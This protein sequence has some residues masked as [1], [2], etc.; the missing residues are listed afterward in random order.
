MCGVVV[1]V[2]LRWARAASGSEEPG[3]YKFESGRGVGGLWQGLLRLMTY[4]A[5]D[6]CRPLLS[7][8]LLGPGLQMRRVGRELQTPHCPHPTGCGPRGGGEFTSQGNTC[9]L[10]WTVLLEGGAGYVEGA[11]EGILENKVKQ[12]HKIYEKKMEMKIYKSTIQH[13]GDGKKN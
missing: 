3:L 11:L 5:G 9:L 2:G 12:E 6:A 10:P 1:T 8:V 13:S 4:L 7:L